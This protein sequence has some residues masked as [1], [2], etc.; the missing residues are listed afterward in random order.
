MN[1][2]GKKTVAEIIRSE[3]LS[4]NNRQNPIY[5]KSVVAWFKQNHPEVRENSVRNTMLFL[6]ANYRGRGKW[7]PG[8]EDDIFKNVAGSGIYYFYEPT[9]DTDIKPIRKSTETEHEPDDA[10]E[11]DI[12]IEPDD[13]EIEPEDQH[14]VK[15]PV[16]F[17][18]V[19]NTTRDLVA[20]NLST[21]FGAG[22]ELY[23]EELASSDGSPEFTL[24]SGGKIDILAINRATN[25]IFV[26]EIKGNQNCS[27]DTLIGQIHRYMSG[28][29]LTVA[30][31]GTRVYGALMILKKPPIALVNAFKGNSDLRLVR[32]SPSIEFSTITKEGA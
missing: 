12:E 30:A 16:D 9:K 1:G 29:R 28:V 25:T 14:E 19:H 10:A 13:A 22:T 23:R 5:I 17:E 21:F 7:G 27:V 26:I 4:F 20:A 8:P 3:F 24:A 32:F 31:P 2:N 18:T 15:L 6:T 11:I